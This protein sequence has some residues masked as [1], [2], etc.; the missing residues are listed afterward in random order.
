MGYWRGDFSS[1]PFSLLSS[2]FSPR[3]AWY[4][5]YNEGGQKRATKHVQPRANSVAFWKKAHVHPSGF[6]RPILQKNNFA[7]L[8]VSA[9]S[10]CRVTLR[11]YVKKTNTLPNQNTLWIWQRKGFKTKTPAH[12]VKLVNMGFW[13]L[14][15]LL[16]YI[17]VWTKI[18][19]IN[20][21]LSNPNRF[22]MDTLMWAFGFIS[23]FRGSEHFKQ[24]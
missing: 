2:P 9:F 21:V 20:S 10:V 17:H 12:K 19:N 18:S 7:K 1:L 23:N 5:S 11:P 3:N 8:K 16:L 4:S 24:I 22:T 6:A 13:E 14:N 15:S